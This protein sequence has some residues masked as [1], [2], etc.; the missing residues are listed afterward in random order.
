VPT[1]EAVTP[2]PQWIYYPERSRPPEWVHAFVDVVAAARERIDTATVRGLHSDVVLSELAPGLKRLGYAVESGKSAGEKIQR[3]VL[4]GERGT[5]RVP[6]EVDAAHD[7]LGIVVE[8]EAGRG[9]R[10]NAVYRDLVRTSLIVGANFLALG[11]MSDYRHM[12]G[13]R[14]VSVQSFSETRKILDAVYASG[15]L[16]LPFEGVLLFGY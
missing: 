4:F 8:V 14:E 13:E 2:Y 10:G 11:V 1:K 15:R 7:E 6:Y 12:S 16:R 5:V 3:P 9:A